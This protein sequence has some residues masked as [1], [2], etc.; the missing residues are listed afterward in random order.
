M[1]T[2]LEDY[3]D[4][5]FLIQINNKIDKETPCLITLI[6]ILRKKNNEIH[7]NKAKNKFDL[8]CFV[9]FFNAPYKNT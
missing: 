1:R 5:N 7:A 9:Y 2:K 6:L 3:M 4:K 8:N